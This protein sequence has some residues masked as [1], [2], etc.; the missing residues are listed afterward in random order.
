MT[1]H[2]F[3]Y[4]HPADLQELTRRGESADL[5]HRKLSKPSGPFPKSATAY[6]Q[7]KKSCAPGFAGILACLYN[8]Y[9]R[10]LAVLEVLALEKQ[11]DQAR[12]DKLKANNDTL[13][14]FALAWTS[15][16]SLPD[17]K[18]RLPVDT[19]RAFTFLGAAVIPGARVFT[20]RLG[21]EVADAAL[22]ASKGPTDHL[23]AI[24]RTLKITDMAFVTEFANGDSD[25]NHGYHIHGIACIPA[26]VSTQSIRE[27]LA[28]KPDSSSFPP[29]KGYRQRFNNKAI[30][31]DD[32]QT[33]GGW[34][35]YSAKE[36]DFTS[37]RLQ[38][39]PDYASR[40]ATK[41]GRALYEAIKAWLHS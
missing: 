1:A 22:S 33:P 23:S 40:S 12:I 32:I 11:I 15:G 34:A 29:R 19:K 21:H 25:E 24:I 38:S 31:I 27:I 28:P 41:S 7:Q 16:V 4:G 30:R 37:H 6:P 13:K 17:W 35:L 39:S 2:Y 8:G 5:K 10:N 14:G 9:M 26:T 18:R 20:F 3:P 36:I